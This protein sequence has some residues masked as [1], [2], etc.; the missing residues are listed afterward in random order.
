[1]DEGTGSRYLNRFICAS[2][3]GTICGALYS[4]PAD[5]AICTGPLAT[6]FPSNRNRLLNQLAASLSN[7]RSSFC[8]PI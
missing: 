4:K 6:D 2:E 3:T 1:M 8:L 5:A 7:Y